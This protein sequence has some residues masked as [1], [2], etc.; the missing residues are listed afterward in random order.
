MRSSRVWWTLGLAAL[1]VVAVFFV[2]RSGVFAPGAPPIDLNTPK[3]ASAGTVGT[4]YANDAAT[5]IGTNQRATYK[6]DPPTSGQHWGAPAAPTAWGIKDTTLPNEVV[7]HNLEH[8]GVI[9]F[10]KDLSDAEK[11][12]LTDLVR[13]IRSQGFNKIVLEPYPALKDARIALSA[14]DWGLKLQAY[15]DVQIV[16]FVKQHHA[17][18]DAPERNSP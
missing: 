6:Q 5:H 1:A 14:W 10:Y 2:V 18:P 12:Q 8:G 11:A 3:Y 15:D 17:G 13:A 7:V 16:S 4:K 9:V